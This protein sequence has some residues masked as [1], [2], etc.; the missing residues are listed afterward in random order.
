MNP[1]KPD[2][3]VVIPT[4]NDAYRLEEA[5][6]SLIQQ[7]FWN[8]EAF[9]VNNI[10]TDHTEEVVN[11]YRDKRITLENF[12]NHGIIAASRNLGIKL[13]R[14]PMIAFLDSDDK[15][16]PKKLEIC[17]SKIEKGYDI[18]CHSERWYNER[19]LDRKIDY[20]PVVA[21][22]YKN[23][24]FKGNCLSTSAVVVRR[25][26]LKGVGGF[27]EDKNFV[28]AEDYDLWLKISAFGAKFGFIN[29]VL[30]FY[31]LHQNSA[32]RAIFK[33]RR[34]ELCVVNKHIGLI[35][36]KTRI[37]VFRRKLKIC[38]GLLK[39]FVYSSIWIRK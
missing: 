31:R 24:L 14:A 39:D 36:K 27:S 35:K 25:D 28:T 11:S 29:D 30:G 7:T 18:V 16:Y 22:N 26:L 17:L 13:A 21:S 1:I 12:A 37:L 20:G 19:G 23:L 32:S 4:F 3:T 9:I 34:A 2:V 33:H 5:L 38:L 8:W 10:S 6:D 15:W